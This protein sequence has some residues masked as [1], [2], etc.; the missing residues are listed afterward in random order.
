MYRP[1]REVSGDIYNFFNIKDRFK[2]LFFADATGHGVSAALVTAIILMILDNVLKKTVHPGQV[3]EFLNKG[4]SERLMSSFFATGVF[5]VFDEDNTCYFTNAGHNPPIFIRPSEGTAE[6]LSKSGPPL[7]MFDEAEFKA[8]RL[9][10]KPGDKLIIYSDALVETKNAAGEMF[11]L[12]RV[13][14]LLEGNYHNSGED[15]LKLL[16]SSLDSFA[17]EYTDD[18]SIIVLEIPPVSTAKSSRGVSALEK[19]L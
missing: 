18:F 3:I 14:N 1:L 13:M 11:N 15:I 19:A 9:E 10:V 2:A 17:H 16:E 4:L 8:S 7:G 6:L 12:E 5:F